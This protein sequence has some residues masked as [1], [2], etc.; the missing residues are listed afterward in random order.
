M[1][2]GKDLATVGVGGTAVVVGGT[3]VAVA[4]TIKPPSGTN[5]LDDTYF[6]MMWALG[7]YRGN[8]TPQL[9]T[10]GDTISSP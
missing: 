10:Q 2:S 9:G 7:Y 1:E 8:S 3:T 4:A 5:L 6:K